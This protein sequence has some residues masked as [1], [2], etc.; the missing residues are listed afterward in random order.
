[1]NYSYIE[2]GLC[3]KRSKAVSGCYIYIS[4]RDLEVKLPSLMSQPVRSFIIDFPHGYSLMVD[5]SQIW[6][7]PLNVFDILDFSWDPTLNLLFD[8]E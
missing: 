3:S 6:W 4:V 2:G 5:Y 1:M 8:K 7:H